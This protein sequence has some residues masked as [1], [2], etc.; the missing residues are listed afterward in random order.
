MTRKRSSRWLR[1]VAN[2][3]NALL[4]RHPLKAHGETARREERE[5]QAFRDKLDRDEVKNGSQD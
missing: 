4:K 1:R 5:A 2:R 3:V